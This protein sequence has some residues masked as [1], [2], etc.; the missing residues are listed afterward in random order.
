[1]S[2]TISKQRIGTTTLPGKMTRSDV[3]VTANSRDMALLA[4]THSW[5][6][7]R[8]YLALLE[9]QRVCGERA[10]SLTGSH[11]MKLS[12]LNSSSSVRRAWT[13]LIRKLS[14]E[15]LT[16]SRTQN[17]PNYKVFEPGEVF[18]RRIASGALPYSD[19]IAFFEQSSV[20]DL[21]ACNVV[22]RSDL[23]RKEALVIL[24][25]VEGFSNAEI[26][27]KLEIEEKTVK[28]HLRNIFIKLGI[29]RRTELISRLIMAR[30]ENERNELNIV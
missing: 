4:L 30:A 18:G 28:Y 26:A 6:E 5:M 3:D 16:S 23:S 13:G 11:L 27:R 12:G 8:L 9:N 7:H 21:V 24:F 29:K 25:C 14:V 15:S 17:S 2:Q 1:M 20:F 19:E 10:P 22:K